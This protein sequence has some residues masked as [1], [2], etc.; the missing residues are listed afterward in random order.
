VGASVKIIPLGGL[1]EIGLNM[2]VFETEDHIM[3]VDAGIMFPEDYM[4]GI[5]IVV[6]EIGYLREKQSMIRG[7]VLTHGHEDHIGALPYVLNE[8]NVPIYGTAFTLALV[9]HKLRSHDFDAIPPLIEVKPR[10]THTIGPFDV[11]F[12]RVSHSVIDG[13]GLAVQTPAGCIVHSG[14]FK[15]NQIP[16]QGELT[17]MNRFAEY[18]ER[19]V[20]ALLSD[21]TNVE[22][23]GYTLSEKEIGNKLHEIFEDCQGRIVV[24]LFSSNIGRI[25]QIVRAARVEGRKIVFCGRSMT[26]SV[27]IAKSLGLLEVPQDMEITTGRIKDTPDREVIIVTTGSQGEPMSV[28]HRIAM[29]MHKQIKIKEGDTVILSSKFIPG[30]ER[31]ITHI[32]NRLYKGGA[33]VIYEKVSDIHVSGHAF[34]EELKLMMNLTK[35]RYFIPI[36]GE[37]RHLIRHTQLAREVG[38]SK[39]H[40]LLAQNGQIISFDDAGGHING[41]VP[42]GRVLIDGKG[43]GDV[44]RSVLKERRLLSLEGLIIVSMVMN[45]DTGTIM[46]GPSLESHGFVVDSHKSETLEAAKDIITEIIDQD[47]TEGSNRKYVLQGKIKKALQKYLYSVIH[48]R[49]VVFPIILEV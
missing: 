48:R 28:L 47:E 8:I 18:G 1:G 11:E 19:G 45:R 41:S 30:N 44:E 16:V 40:I 5:D 9:S 38:I 3:I 23:E 17:D 20:L 37:Y 12:I 14:D 42:S 4:L 43:V 46:E 29:D 36:H 32:I 25:Q 22:R 34:Q 31:A 39:A 15:I 13:V 6:P 26:A 10:E 35:P 27:N 2:M 21:S 49:P 7:I 24:A 33:R